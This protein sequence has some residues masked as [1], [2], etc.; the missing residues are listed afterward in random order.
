MVSTSVGEQERLAD[1]RPVATLTKA[2]PTAADAEKRANLN[3]INVKGLTFKNLVK[4]GNFIGTNN[5]TS[6]GASFTAASNVGT[7]TA[8]TQNDTLT[9]AI[10]FISGHVYYI[11]A[12][13][14]VAS[15][16]V[17]FFVNDGSTDFVTVSHSATT[18][19]EVMSDVG[20]AAAS[21]SFNL[22]I[23]DA[24]A[25]AW[26]AI[27]VKNVVVLDL[28]ELGTHPSGVHWH[29]LTAEQIDTYID[30]YPAQTVPHSVDASWVSFAEAAGI[31]ILHLTNLIQNGQ[32]NSDITGWGSPASVTAS[33]DSGRM[34]TVGLGTTS[35]AYIQ[36]TPVITGNAVYMYAKVTSMNA[37]NYIAIYDGG[38][39]I[40]QQN[41]PTIGVTYTL[42]VVDSN[43]DNNMVRIIASYAN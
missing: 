28:T 26:T 22:T 16:D 30:D 34:K 21:G 31:P 43:A 35:S 12:D 13:I 17:S 7:F 5:F 38:S 11:H 15:A 25:S 41:N 2:S 4:G 20:V 37:V 33:W 14:N 32:F 6:N 42:S 8:D 39:I 36:Q 29:D 24:R 18:G 19:Y 9:Q 3:S 1:R 40:S 23:K 27:L 10:S